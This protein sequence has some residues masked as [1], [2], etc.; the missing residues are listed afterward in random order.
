MAVNVVLVVANRAQHFCSARGKRELREEDNVPS[1]SCEACR[2]YTNITSP[3]DL[4]VLSH[5]DRI[6][7][8]NYLAHSL[9]WDLANSHCSEFTKRQDGLLSY[10]CL[11]SSLGSLSSPWSLQEVC[12]S[13]PRSFCILCRA[14]WCWCFQQRE[15]RG[16]IPCQNSSQRS[17]LVWPSLL[18]KYF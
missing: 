16:R 11:F 18:N 2:E 4:G 5:K 12:T 6:F 17:S 8:I 15:V 3:E 1:P 7:A 9:Q 13:S 10:V 14:A